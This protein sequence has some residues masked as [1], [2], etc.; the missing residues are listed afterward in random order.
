MPMGFRKPLPIQLVLHLASHSP[1]PLDSIARMEVV[2]L[3][4]QL[5]ASAL[6]DEAGTSGPRG[7]GDEAR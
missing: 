7:D 5:L 1:S 4:A 3:L 2:H 6:G